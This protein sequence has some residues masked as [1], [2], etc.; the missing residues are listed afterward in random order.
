MSQIE[1]L[2]EKLHKAI[3]DGG[4]DE[5]LKISQELDKIIVCYMMNQVDDA[6]KK[7]A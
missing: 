1:Y 3:A 2:R 6:E 7:T 4:R 5:I